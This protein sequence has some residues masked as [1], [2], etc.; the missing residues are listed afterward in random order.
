[1]RKWKFWNIVILTLSAVLTLACAVFFTACAPQ[2]EPNDQTGAQT[3]DDD[4]PIITQVEDATI[5]GTNIFMLVD[6]TTDNVPLLNKVTVSSGRWGLYADILGQ[7]EIPTKI[8][9]G[10]NGKL[11]DGNNIFYI[12]L[13][14]ENGD[15]A[16]VYTLTIH[17]I[18]SISVSYYDGDVLLETVSA[19]TGSKFMAS[20]TPSIAGYTFNEWKTSSGN[21]FTAETI[22]EPLSLYADKTA[23]SYKVTL[24]V[25]DG[26]ELS[27]TEESVTYD[28]AY[29][30]AVPTRTGYTFIGWYVGNVRI[31]DGKGN[32]LIAW[33]YASDQT[34]TALWS[35]NQYTVMLQ[36]NDTSA[37]SV[38]GAGKHAYASTVTVSATTNNGYTFL[39]WYDANDNLVTT[40]ARYTFTMGAD[41]QTYIAK[42]EVADAMKNFNFTA[43][44]TTCTITGIIETSITE[45]VVPDYVTAISQGVFAGCSSLESITLPFAGGSVKKAT[46]IYQYPFGYIFG[47]NSYTG[48]TAV[49]QYYYGS[50]TSSTTSTTYYIP[51]SLKEVMITGGNILYGA[52]YNCSGLTSIAIPS[53][54]T[55]IGSSAF[56]G[57]SGLMSITI[58]DSVT[59]I[60]ER[61]F[62]GCSKLTEITIPD[63]V[64]SIGNSTFSGCSELTS[65]T[66]DENSQLT[67]VGEMAFSGCSKLTEITIPDSVTWIGYDAFSGCSSLESM[68]LPFVGGSVFA[69]SASNSTLFGYIFGTNSYNGG[70]AVTQYYYYGSST[71][72]RTHITYY[73]PSS[74]KEVMI[75]GGNILYGAF[76]NCSGLTSIAIPSSVTS[77]GDSAFFNC[78]ALT[79][80]I[81]PDS[82]TS[83]GSS[84][85]FWC[86]RLTNFTIPDSVTSIGSSAFSYCSGLT[87][88]TFVNTSGWWVSSSRTDRSITS[89][90]LSDSATAATYLKSTYAGY[91]WERR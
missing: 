4:I 32:G 8:A 13:G 53:S 12:M 34:V 69:T 73:I 76:Y 79:S 18:Y 39:G 16:E 44:A 68:T 25:N 66:F 50:S 82:V 78:S 31:T 43:T 57:C 65:A 70:T 64:T 59:S 63:G 7:N 62:S 83:I 86:T 71:S 19:Y 84:A 49:T 20:Y 46:D 28:S 88:V 67:S 26:D 74:L 52:F 77:I 58:P 36:Q 10:S 21:A 42:W 15:L 75:T 72:S 1:M 47:T 2:E 87:S 30:F 45:I 48:G 6:Y 61:A 24:D 9:A 85:F 54:V 22:W 51:S 29:S 89:S 33:K 81:I 37:G 56:S 35:V 41:T 23:N 14:N 17:R 3:P 5:D 60:G 55:S 91:Y 11:Q 40:D 80:I 38:S 90:D 27:T